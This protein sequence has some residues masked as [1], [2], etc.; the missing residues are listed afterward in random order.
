MDK[1]ALSSNGRSKYTNI[2]TKIK[3]TNRRN[4]SSI[5]VIIFGRVALDYGSIH[6]QN[7]SQ[8]RCYAKEIITQ[9][10]LIGKAILF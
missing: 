6:V 7:I 9:H 10:N 3:E 1:K 4:T 5:I 8:A 2:V